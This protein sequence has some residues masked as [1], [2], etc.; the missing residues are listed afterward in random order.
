[1]DSD[2]EDWGAIKPV[3]KEK[4]KEKKAP[5]S[6]KKSN[7]PNESPKIKQEFPQ[8]PK[9][10]NVKTENVQQPAVRK[11]DVDEKERSGSAE[12]QELKRARVDRIA[13]FQMRIK[14][15]HGP[16]TV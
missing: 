5:P 7:E 13:E 3:R 1:M 11:P 16:L 8:E 9:K 15:L 4:E 14:K 2:D 6:S 10:S 12:E